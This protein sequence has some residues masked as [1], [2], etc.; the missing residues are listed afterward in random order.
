MNIVLKNTIKV[1]DSQ[2]LFWEKR[3]NIGK[4]S[5]FLVLI[6]ILCSLISLLVNN[7]IISLGRL[8]SKF[9]HPFFAIEVA[10]TILLILELLSLIFVLPKSVSRSLG[11]QLELLSLIFLRNTFKEFSHLDEF[12]S[13]SSSQAT[14]LIMLAYSFGALLMFLLLGYTYKLHRKIRISETFSNQLQF[15]R[16]K[17]ILALFLLIS[18]IIIGC[19]D[20][21]V[22]VRTGVYLHS[23]H[24]FYTVLIFTDIIIVLVAL[25]YTINY[26][27]VFRYSAFV[28]ATIFIRIALTIEP[29]YDVALGIITACFILFLAGAYNYIQKDLTEK[30]LTT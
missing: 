20:L 28:L 15:V 26:Y 1:F 21:V 27:R 13:W 11:K 22:L 30:E 6:F 9:I 4:L 8:D 2:V 3:Q 14:I 18:F 17:K 25:R 7:N 16:I 10:F 5:S 29:Y 19:K 24:S 12:S 23:F